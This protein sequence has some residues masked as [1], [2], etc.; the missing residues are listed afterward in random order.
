MNETTLI[1]A[2]AAFLAGGA[3]A[4]ILAGARARGAGDGRLQELIASRAAAES[5]TVELRRQSEAM[6][7]DLAAMQQQVQ[8]EQAARASAQTAQEKAEESLAERRRLLDDAE[9]S[10][11]DAFRALASQAL[12]E[13]SQQFLKLAGE[14][15]QVL[16]QRAV[17]DMAQ[18][19]VSIEGLVKPLHDSV[20][21]LEDHLNKFEVSWKGDKGGLSA[22]IQQLAESNRLLRQE[23]GSLVTSLRQPHIK[24]KWGE[25][26][27]RRAVELAGMSPHCDFTEQLT[28]TTEEG[29]V[30]PDMVVHLPGGGSIVVDAKVP[31][32]AFLKALGC[33]NQDEY[34]EAM[35]EHAQL[36][37]TH[38]TQLGSKRYWEQFTPSPEFVVLFL[39]AESYFS[40]A[41]EEDGGLI[42]DAMQKGVVLASPTTLLALL[43]AVAYGWN[44]QTTAQG[45]QRIAD[46]GKELHRRLL[47]FLDHMAGVGAGL[48][49]ANK[50]YNSAAG[51]AE[52]MLLPAARKFQTLSAP[53]AEEVP[54][55]APIETLPRQ[56]SIPLEDEESR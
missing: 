11:K 2:V 9:T 41:L 27:L 46:L 55:L 25:L 43:K 44:Q 30:R 5:T 24:G 36:V 54:S 42:E 20:A 37:R 8:R 49:R 21:K 38:V 10:L 13:S 12:T 15:F 28:L 18:K 17:G 50:A 40:A 52:S 14:S 4:W 35:V 6:R 33:K 45:A 56:I 19:E 47:R 7:V 23:T 31:L 22:E 34:H 48:E 39:P 29:R 53:G 32:H 51:S 26:L 16:Q 1:L 3:I